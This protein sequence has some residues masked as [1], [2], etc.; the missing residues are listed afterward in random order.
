MQ[1]LTSQ[2]QVPLP[3][4]ITSK[5]FIVPPI[6]RDKAGEV[7][8]T[9]IDKHDYSAIGW[10]WRSDKKAIPRLS[11][12]WLTADDVS[13]DKR[14]ESVVLYVHGGA[15]YMGSTMTHRLLTSGIAKVNFGI[16]L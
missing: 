9:A 5:D 10:D 11:G 6:Y 14:N 2:I 7:L 4:F 3:P 12:E 1:W 15:G 8:E 16:P 13:P